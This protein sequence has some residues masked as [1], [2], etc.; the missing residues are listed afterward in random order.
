M[1]AYT[2]V[3]HFITQVVYAFGVASY[4]ISVY[5]YAVY[6]R[7]RRERNVKKE[8]ESELL[9]GYLYCLTR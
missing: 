9:N 7:A 6:R 5:K 8:I 3:T 4:V 2:T 1:Y